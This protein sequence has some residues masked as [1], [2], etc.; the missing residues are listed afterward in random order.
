MTPE[1][2]ALL[3]S[4]ARHGDCRLGSTQQAQ[5]SRAVNAHIISAQ[6]NPGSR[7]HTACTESITLAAHRLSPQPRGI[8]SNSVQILLGSISVFRECVALMGFQ[9][10]ASRNSISAF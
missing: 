2:R 7:L 9:L 3:A 6:G 4:R 1:Q 8:S 5:S 10:L